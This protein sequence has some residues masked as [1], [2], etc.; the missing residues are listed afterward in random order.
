MIIVLCFVS[1][2]L[3]DVT[4]VMMAGTKI[5]FFLRDVYALHLQTFFVIVVMETIVMVLKKLNSV[6]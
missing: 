1:V 2:K 4:A 6:A 3:G 5:S